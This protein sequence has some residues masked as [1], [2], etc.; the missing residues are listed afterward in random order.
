MVCTKCGNMMS[1]SD[2]YCSKCGVKVRVI[3]DENKD[4]SISAKSTVRKVNMKL[5][6]KKK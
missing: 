2:V 3:M 5:P 1:N 6:K 4:S